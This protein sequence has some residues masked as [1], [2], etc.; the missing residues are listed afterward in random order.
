MLLDALL[1]FFHFLF[2][3][4]MLSVLG[5]EAYV[6][7]LPMTKDSVQLITQMDRGYGISAGLLVLAGV[8]RVIW[9]A[10]GADYYIHEPYFWAKMATF[11]AIGI[12]SIF[13]TLRF[14]RWRKALAADPAF[15]PDAAETKRAHA[16]V[17]TQ[18]RLMAVVIAFAVLMAR[19]FGAT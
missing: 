5:G 1:A 2:L 15:L 10:K 13:P 3:F 4:G 8:S 19:G 18:L 9:G 7:R 12:I 6:L 14:F 17:L 16:L 11:A